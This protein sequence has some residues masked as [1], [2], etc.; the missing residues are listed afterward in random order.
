MNADVAVIGVGTMGSM[1]MWQLAKRGAAVIGFEQFGI[2]HDRSAA[3]GESRLFRT[4][5]YAPLKNTNSLFVPILLESYNLWREL[6]KETGQDLL[7][8]NGGL[9]MGNPDEEFVK[10]IMEA[11]HEFQLDHEI[12]EGESAKKRFPQHRLL[13]GEIMVLD[14]LAGYIRP[15]LSVVTASRR[16]EELGAVIH[17]YTCVEEI[18]Q[19]NERVRIKANGKNYYV[20]KVVISAGPWTGKFLRNV[21]KSVITPKKIGMTW[22]PSKNISLFKPDRFPGFMRISNGINFFGVPTIDGTM[23][24]VAL[25]TLYGDIEDPYHVDKNIAIDE[26]ETI[27]SA[28][29]SF[30]PDLIPEPTRVSVHMD[31]YTEDND[32]MV[33]EVPGMKNVFVISGFSGGGFKMAPGM[34]KI[35]AD[36]ILDGKTY[37]NIDHLSPSRF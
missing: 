31:G 30:L 22:Y 3:G 11:I 14:K 24:K 36:L 1:V 23:V 17:R 10:N 5:G 29:Q 4:A 28:V 21:K 18:E 27:N 16:A 20:G 8:I 34:G 9:M 33:G 15:E 7:T 19:E 37:H 13:D 32:S 12:F 26:L 6:E 2:G 25:N 35:G